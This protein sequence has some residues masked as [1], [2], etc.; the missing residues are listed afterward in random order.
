MVWCLLM[1]EKSSPENLELLL[2][3]EWV[4]WGNRNEVQCG[5]KQKDGRMLLHWAAQY[6]E[7]YHFVI[8]LTPVTNISVQHV[9]RWNPPTTSCFKCNVDVAVF[10]ELKS[11][12][13][14]VIVRDWHGHFVAACASIYMHHWD[15][16]KQ[17]RKLLKLVCSSQSSWVY[18]TSSWRVIR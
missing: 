13:I 4:L 3:Y 10:A 7:E 8:A 2:T 16:L 14:G 11:V 12:G 9:Q 18:Q 1:D 5:G 17:N 15:L 6:L